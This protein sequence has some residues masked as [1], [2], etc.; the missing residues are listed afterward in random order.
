[1]RIFALATQG[2]GNKHEHHALALPGTSQKEIFVG[3]ELGLHLHSRLLD[4]TNV[5][6]TVTVG[7]G[8]CDS[9]VIRL[10]GNSSCKS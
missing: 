7:A 9:E 10:P 6:D 1:M 5:S 2:H 3:E 8:L 4:L